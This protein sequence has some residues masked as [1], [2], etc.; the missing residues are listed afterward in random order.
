MR[1]VLAK[2]RECGKYA[3]MRDFPHDCGTVDTY[4]PQVELLRANQVP[5]RLDA[6]T[7]QNKWT[8]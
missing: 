1:D 7:H 2:M 5:L 3:K 4:V 8:A 6:P